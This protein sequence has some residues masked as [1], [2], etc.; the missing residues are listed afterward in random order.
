MSAESARVRLNNSGLFDRITRRSPCLLLWGLLSSG[1]S[2]NLYGVGNQLLIDLHG[3]N[4][5][6]IANS[7]ISL[8]DR[9]FGTRIGGHFSVKADLHD[10]SG[11]R[12]DRY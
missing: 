11:C 1:R 7:D 2:P 9:L 6:P 4:H 5:D 3:V 12:L 10:F 8:L